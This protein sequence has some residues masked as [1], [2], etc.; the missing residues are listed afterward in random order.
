EFQDTSISQYD[1][2]TKLTAGW[3]P[4]DGRSMLVVGDPMQS[5][6]RFRQAEVGLF[7]LARATGFGNV[8]LSPISLS[9]NFRSQ[10]GIVDWVNTTFAS[11]MP[12]L[13]NISMGSVR[14]SPSVAVRPELPDAAVSVHPFFNDDHAAEGAK[15]VEI[16]TRGQRDENCS[17]TAI[18]VRNRSHLTEILPRLKKAGLRF[19]A[20]EIEGLSRQPVVQDL[21]VLTRALMHPADR[22]AWLALLRAPW[23]GLTLADLHALVS[24]APAPSGFYDLHDAP[25]TAQERE[26][27]AEAV[28]GTVWGWLQDENRIASVSADGYE[29]LLRMRDVLRECMANRNR[30]SLRATVEAAWLAL[31]GPACLEDETGLEDAS[32]YLDYLESHEDAG[33]IHSLV[34]LEEGLAGLSALPDAKADDSLQIMTIHKAKGLEFDCVIVPGLGRL[35]RS[36]DKKLFMWME[37]LRDEWPE[38]EAEEERESSGGNDLL[39]APIQET[40][41]GSDPIYSWMERLDDEKECLEDGRLLYVAATRAR[42]RLH[43]LG[44]TGAITGNEGRLQLKPPPAK[45]L[46]SKIWPAVESFY[47]EAAAKAAFSDI[48]FCGDSKEQEARDKPLIDQALRRLVSR[49]ELPPAPHALRWK[50][51]QPPL[52][53]WEEVEYSWAGET[54]RL[55][56]NIVHSWLQRIAEDGLAN[57]NIDRIRGLQ[58]VF[59]RQLIACGAISAGKDDPDDAVKRVMAALTHAVS[60]PRGQWLLG[61]QQEARS[62]LRMTGNI[63]GQYMDFVIDR[64]FRDAEGQR[65]VVDYKTSSHEGADV[66]GFLNRE[67]ERYRDQLDRYAALMQAAEGQPVRRG[68]YFPLLKGWR[69][70]GDEA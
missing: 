63:G 40:G 8:T 45:T 47:M 44:S 43:L 46:L 38:T 29:R 48:Q 15:V 22:L 62:E 57:W 31:G 11:V 59:R 13:E 6:Y 41:S 9:A 33:S 7:L 30:Q 28:P 34:A 1:L 12:Q 65:W 51:G 3:E 36:D 4:G 50:A 70:W 23:C 5:I 69:E 26:E 18:L 10:C 32:A 16:L 21:L 66:E 35:S 58:D 64:T 42:K 39:L 17:T 49:W 24:T 25:D 27:N 14:Y 55:V 54:A 68:L 53:T 2:V 61:P 37:H 19:R 56:G 52:P 67:Q 20:I 60:E